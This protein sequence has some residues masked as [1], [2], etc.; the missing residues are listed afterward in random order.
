MF[1][2]KNTFDKYTVFTS[3]KVEFYSK[4]IFSE[5][6]ESQAR[7]ESLKIKISWT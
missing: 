1:K 7:Q 2:T 5:L 4:Q 6:F 3:V